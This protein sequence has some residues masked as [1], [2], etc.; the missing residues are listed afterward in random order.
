MAQT[1]NYKLQTAIDYSDVNIL[2]NLKSLLRVEQKESF[3]GI[4]TPRS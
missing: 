1:V 4:K 2:A 3:E